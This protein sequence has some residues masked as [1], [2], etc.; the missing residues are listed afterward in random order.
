MNETTQEGELTRQE[1]E[2]FILKLLLTK[3][4]RTYSNIKTEDHNNN[5]THQG[6]MLS[7]G[8]IYNYIG[9]LVDMNLIKKIGKSP[10]KVYFSDVVKEIYELVIENPINYDDLLSMNFHIVNLK[11]IIDILINIKMM[12]IYHSNQKRIIKILK[13]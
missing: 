3:E 2:W 11:D 9:H 4:G 10:F 6:K 8:T 5:I 13:L 12:K 7:E 1:K